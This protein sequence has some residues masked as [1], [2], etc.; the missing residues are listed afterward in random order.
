MKILPRLLYL[1]AVAIGPLVFNSPAPACG[2]NCAV[3]ATVYSSTYSDGS[4]EPG[5]SLCYYSVCGGNCTNS[6]GYSCGVGPYT[7]P[8]CDFLSGS[9]WGHASC[10]C[11]YFCSQ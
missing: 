11:D 6:Q 5:S 3:G 4:C 10:G 8:N 7:P 9:C 1:V 2:G